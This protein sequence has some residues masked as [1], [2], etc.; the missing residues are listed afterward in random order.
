MDGFW[1]G[2]GL[3]FIVLAMCLPWILFSGEPDLI[4]AIKEALMK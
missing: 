3:F 2:F 1:T 4:D